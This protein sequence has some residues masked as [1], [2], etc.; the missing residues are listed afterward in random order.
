MALEFICEHVFN[1]NPANFNNVLFHDTPARNK[2]EKKQMDFN[3][4]CLD[5]F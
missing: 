5:G 4:Y 2:K 3:L 1:S